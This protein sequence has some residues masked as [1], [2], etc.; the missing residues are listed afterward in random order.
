[1]NLKGLASGNYMIRSTDN[2]INLKK[3]FII[4]N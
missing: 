3:Q 1:M 4:N 2:E